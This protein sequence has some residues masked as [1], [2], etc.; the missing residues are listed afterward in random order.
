LLLQFG[1]LDTRLG[2]AF[3]IGSYEA[4]GVVAS[5]PVQLIPPAAAAAFI[6]SVYPPS[7]SAPLTL[8]VGCPDPLLVC[9]PTTNVFD[10]GQTVTLTVVDSHDP[11]AQIGWPAWYAINLSAVYGGAMQTTSVRLYVGAKRLY[12]PHVTRIARYNQ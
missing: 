11:G 9:S 7:F 8:T 5:P 3:D 4:A 1:V 2:D 10:T 6:L 12:L